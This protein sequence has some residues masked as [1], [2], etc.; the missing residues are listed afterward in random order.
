MEIRH[1]DI[2][3]LQWF[4]L[5]ELLPKDTRIITN[6]GRPRLDDRTVLAAIFYRVKTGVPC[7]HIPPMF[8]S[9]STLHRRF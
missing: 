4:K 9:K 7:R 8:G 5:K 2:P 3:E 1:L 6:G